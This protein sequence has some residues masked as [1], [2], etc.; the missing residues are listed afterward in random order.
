MSQTLTFTPGQTSKNVIVNTTNDTAYELAETVLMSL[1]NPSGMTIAT[2]IGTGTIND[3]DSIPILS[4]SGTN[5]TEG[6]TLQFT[7]SLT[8]ASYQNVTV[9][10][11]TINSS[12]TAGSDYTTS[13]G[14]VTITS[15]STS[16]TINVPTTNDTIFEGNE[17]FTVQLT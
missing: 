10:Y 17:Y 5:A 11:T 12:A 2:S 1:S 6:Q 15:G 14:A 4:I 9:S 13:T 3:N 8:N 7:V 16:T